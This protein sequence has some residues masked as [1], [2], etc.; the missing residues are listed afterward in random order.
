MRV[1][2]SGK[3]SAALAWD[4]EGSE[5]RTTTIKVDVVD[6]RKWNAAVDCE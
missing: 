5:A 2:V 4:G 3:C 6:S 1:Y